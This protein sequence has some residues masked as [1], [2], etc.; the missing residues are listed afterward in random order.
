MKI[1]DLR[2]KTIDASDGKETIEVELLTDRGRS[3]A[4]VPAG[5]STGKY[6]VLYVTAQKAKNEIEGIVKKKVVGI[7]VE[8]QEKID[9]ILCKLP[10]G[11]NSRLAV[12]I[13]VCRAGN[14]L[15]KAG[16]SKKPIYLV[17]VFEGGR[18]GAGKL[19]F[20]EF[21][22]ASDKFMEGKGIFEKLV[23]YCNEKKIAYRFGAEGAINP[24]YLNNIEVLDILKKELIGESRKLALD[25]AASH[26]DKPV[27]LK[28]YDRIVSQYPVF[29]IEDPYGEDEWELWGEFFRKA[30]EKITIVADDLVTT[31]KERLKNAIDKKVCNGVIIK[32]NQIGTVSQTL[33]VIKLAKE[34]NLVTVVSHRGAETMDDFIADLAYYQEADF[35]KFGG[36]EQKERLAKYYRMES[37]AS[38]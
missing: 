25:V 37:L 21:M 18:H 26:F 16:V 20:Q 34:K 1:I 27:D 29:L 6:E 2:V 5:I 11:G 36:F 9:D 14:N 28:E 19:T 30:G 10:V 38:S 8:E 22:V 17:L 13:V 35:V 24:L 7:N 31:N 32:P 3:V 4:S 23:D 33:Q 15:V 12:S